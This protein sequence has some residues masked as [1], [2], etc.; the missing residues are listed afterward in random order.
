MVN[1]ERDN[2][3]EFDREVDRNNLL[4]EFKGKTNEIDFSEYISSI[5]MMKSIR[6]GDISLTI[7]VLNKNNFL[8]EKAEI[9]VGN[10]KFLNT[11]QKKV[12]L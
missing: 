2:I 6:D 4:Y 3:E 10:P 12:N 8:N 7:A 1:K 11:S 5:D 9:S